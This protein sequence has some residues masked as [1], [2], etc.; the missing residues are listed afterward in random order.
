MQHDLRDAA[1]EAL[2]LLLQHLARTLVDGRVRQHHHLRAV[3]VLP[4]AAAAA[5]L[6]LLLVVLPCQHLRLH[7]CRQR[8]ATPPAKLKITL[9]GS[10]LV[11][12]TLSSLGWLAH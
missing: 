10:T 12:C 2:H 11:E 5:A 6:L 7:Q 3:L 8:P 9:M 1:L 4:V